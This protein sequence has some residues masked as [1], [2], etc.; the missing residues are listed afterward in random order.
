MTDATSKL[1]ERIKKLLAKAE[2]TDNEEEAQTF[3]DKAMGM[4]AEHEISRAD[5][6]DVAQGPAPI[7]HK[8][9]MADE[10]W[11][12][13]PY[14]NPRASMFWRIGKV[15]GVQAYILPSRTGRTTRGMGVVGT[16]AAIDRTVAIFRL[17][18]AQAD[19]VVLGARPPEWEN[20]RTYRRSMFSGFTD[21]FVERLDAAVNKTITDD[22]DHDKSPMALAI[23]NDRQRAD[24]WAK[25]NLNL[26]PARRSSG[27]SHRGRN[28]GSSAANGA[29]LGNSRVQNTRRELNA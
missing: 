3:F 10:L 17:A 9:I 12:D 23:L 21:T 2:G 20:V 13:L 15:L 16:S 22:G 6:G 28:A 29:D 14:S 24:Q 27:S 25:E 5:L 18:Q 26:V 8:F 1:F 4:M 11:G 19:R 7:E